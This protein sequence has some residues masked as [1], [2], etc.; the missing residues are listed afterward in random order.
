MADITRTAALRKIE[1]SQIETFPSGLPTHCPLVS[2]L[3]AISSCRT[4]VYDWLR[5]ATDWPIFG[6]SWE[7]LQQ[8]EMRRA[9]PE[10]AQNDRT[11][12]ISSWKRWLGNADRTPIGA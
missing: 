5:R 12:D 2:G 6:S 11:G 10:L 1:S 4:R 7:R 8:G 3:A 9:W